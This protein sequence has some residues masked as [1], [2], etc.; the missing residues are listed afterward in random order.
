MN[1]P[2]EESEI[3]AIVPEELEPSVQED[4]ARFAEAVG[5]E[6]SL[7]ATRRID[8][9]ALAQSGAIVT[10]HVGRYRALKGLR[11]EDIGLEPANDRQRTAYQRTLKL[12]QK[13]LL[14]PEIG[15]AAQAIEDKARKL[16]AAYRLTTYWGDFLP[17]KSYPQWAQAN[18]AVRD[19]YL[20]FGASVAARRDELIAEMAAEYRLIAPRTYRD[21]IRNG[22]DKQQLGP[23][24]AWT[25]AYVA[26]QVALVPSAEEIRLSYTYT[27]ETTRLV[28]PSEAAADQARA[29]RIRLVA[30]EKARLAA[31]D[32]MRADLA[33]TEAERSLQGVSRFLAD[34]QEQI[35]VL[36]YDTVLKGIKALDG[37]DKRTKGS[38]VPRA[39]GML[40]AFVDEV[41]TLQFWEDPDLEAR[42]AELDR[43]VET[44]LPNRSTDAVRVAL[45]DLG[46][47]A[48]LV[49]M[50]IGR[51][52]ARS[53]RDLGI[54]DSPL[55]LQ[56]AV[57]SAPR[58]LPL[59]GSPGVTLA[60]GGR[61]GSGGPILDL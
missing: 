27:W 55:E 23:I 39:A 56:A 46:A 32:A 57:R 28:L 12:G 41:R 5:I 47:R 22:A 58:P 49:L 9:Q 59:N 21:L 29:D 31:E 44:E 35:Q 43:L 50:E 1:A 4:I 24:G 40:K 60:P 19:E 54:P 18:L 3:M 15:S 30:Q 37:I 13:H 2:R 10:L 38:Q 14:P 8:W 53:G 11:L 34:V 26:R 7:V 45:R 42:I 51:P 16:L 6:P 48:R 33:R 20:A 52:P 17:E 61:G 25:D 36:V